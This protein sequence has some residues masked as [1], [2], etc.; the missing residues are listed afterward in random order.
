MYM[1]KEKETVVKV[2]PNFDAI[3]Y[4]IFMDPATNRWSIIEVPFEKSSL[5]VGN[6]RISHSDP[7]K[8]EMIER[9][10]IILAENDI[11]S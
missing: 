1:K 9:L 3:A 4:S 11:V 2:E 6:A 7:Y 10:K 5:L 8:D